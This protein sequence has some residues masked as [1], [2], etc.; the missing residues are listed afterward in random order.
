VLSKLP[1]GADP[2][3]HTTVRISGVPV[4]PARRASLWSLGS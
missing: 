4:L 3:W 1:R 2:S